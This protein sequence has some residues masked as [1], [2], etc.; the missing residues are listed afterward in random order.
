M[1]V[2]AA[3]RL[4]LNKARDIGWKLLGIADH[5]H[6]PHMQLQAHGLFANILWALG[7]FIGSCEHAERGLALF[8]DEQPCQ[9]SKD[10]G[11]P[12]VSSMPVCAQRLWAS[13]T[14]DYRG[15]WSF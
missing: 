4:E 1:S 11:G 15:P 7:D 12:H 13:L 5:E 3:F 2:V 14:G 9:P 8:T 10:T 6:D